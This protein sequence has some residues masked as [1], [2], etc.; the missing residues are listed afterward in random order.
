MSTTGVIVDLLNEEGFK[1][2]AEGDSIIGFE[3]IIGSEYNDELIGDKNDNTIKGGNGDDI[4]KTGGGNDI[5]YGG[6]GNDTFVISANDT[7]ADVTTIMDFA[8]G[9][10]KIDL[11]AFDTLRMEDLE[12]FKNIN[13]IKITFNTNEI[14]L[15]NIE[16]QSLDATSFR[17]YSNRTE[18]PDDNGLGGDI[19]DSENPSG[20]DD[21][22]NA[23]LLV[24]EINFING[25]AA[26]MFLFAL[27]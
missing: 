14:Y 24:S 21:G 19:N 17:F 11:S 3:C 12:I 2:D 15:K 18:D 26:L 27:E 20:D 9:E 1:G 4:L 16:E 23:S 25:I 5:L 10:D 13:D 7:V 8:L 6:R 22:D